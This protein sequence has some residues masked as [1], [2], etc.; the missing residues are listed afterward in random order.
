MPNMKDP[1]ERRKHARF[2]VKSGAVGIIR[3]L[4]AKREQTEDISISK[5]T[6]VTS[7]KYCQIIYISKC[8]ISIRYIDKNGDLNEPFELDVLFIQDSICFTCLK[9]IPCKTVRISHESSK[10]S[11]GQLK[12]IHREVQF[13][14]MTSYQISQLDRFLKKYTIM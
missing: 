3:P 14:K 4:A 13:G 1:V 2:K 6:S 8:G 9:N 11:S 7:A 10:N 12:T 5:I